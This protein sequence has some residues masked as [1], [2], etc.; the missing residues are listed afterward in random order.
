MAKSFSAA[1][2]AWTKKTENRMAEVFR[3]AAATAAEVMNRPIAEGGRMPVVTGNLRNSLAASTI[4]P[5]PALWGRKE[6]F[7]PN[8]DGIAA[9]IDSA[10]LGGTVW[11]GYQAIYAKKAELDHGFVALAAQNWTGI[12]EASVAAVKERS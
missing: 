4:G 5:V 6:P 2:D 3:V 9:V 11:L 1:V 8:P 10:Q 7:A 12:V